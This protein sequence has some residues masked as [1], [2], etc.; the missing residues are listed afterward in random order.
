MGGRR[1]G[2]GLVSVVRFAVVQ[3]RGGFP[4]SV[5]VAVSHDVVQTRHGLPREGDGG[6]DGVLEGPLEDAPEI[7]QRGV[8]LVVAVPH[9]G[10]LT[11]A[12]R[13]VSLVFV[14]LLHVAEAGDAMHGAR[15]ARRDGE[16]RGKKVSRARFSDVP[17]SNTG[18]GRAG[19]DAAPSAHLFG[20]GGRSRR[21]RA[22]A[23][24]AKSRRTRAGEW[25]LDPYPRRAFAFSRNADAAEF[26][27]DPRLSETVKNCFDARRAPM[28]ISLGEDFKPGTPHRLFSKTMS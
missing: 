19:R 14:G 9:R 25:R 2:A 5:V 24:A 1:R 3:L 7:D 11:S 27:R 28:R 20:P 26:S 12:V 21:S 13:D 16:F 17:K 10:P 22:G 6:D 15:S 23:S 4:E 8:L 18:L